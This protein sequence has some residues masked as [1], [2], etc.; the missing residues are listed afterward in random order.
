[1]GKWILHQ[2]SFIS[3][4]HQ[5]KSP[6]LETSL[7]SCVLCIEVYTGETNGT[8]C[9]DPLASTQKPGSKTGTRPHLMGVCLHVIL[10]VNYLPFLR[11]SGARKTW[12][13]HLWLLFQPCVCHIVLH[14]II[15]SSGDSCRCGHLI[16]HVTGDILKVFHRKQVLPQSLWKPKSDHGSWEI[17]TGWKYLTRFWSYKNFLLESL[18]HESGIKRTLSFKEKAE[19]NESK[20]NDRLHRQGQDAFVWWYRGMALGS[21]EH[22]NKTTSTVGFFLIT[23]MNK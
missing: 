20:Q 14:R 7:I 10:H 13:Q 21:T 8:H 2:V 1:M 5:N 16:H 4:K 18:L 23:D 9:R 12:L 19:T 11:G 22:W 6:G 3:H 15:G 17:L